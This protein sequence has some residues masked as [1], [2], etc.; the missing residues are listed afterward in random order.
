M[1][2]HNLDQGSAEW[3]EV[4]LGK[5]SASN[6]K[7]LVTSK[8]APS[9]SMGGY[10]LTLACQAYS[11]KYL[12]SFE[13]NS[14]TER[15]QMLEPEAREYY[16]FV[17]GVSVE[18]VG[19]ITDDL[20]SYGCSPDGLIDSCG[21]LEIKCLKAENHLAA[22]LR[23]TPPTDYIQQVKGSLMIT[24]R[25][26]WDLFFYHPDLP[27]KRYRIYNDPEFNQKLITQ[28]EAVIKERDSILEKLKQMGK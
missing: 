7:K 25:E 21:G 22:I 2:I 5:P 1:K 27:P 9:K 28:I 19:F 15:G 16:E 14:F 20:E 18:E 24:G 13:G 6:F 12:D 26:W 23:D 8:G 11:G 10:A 17:Y 4:R 3:F